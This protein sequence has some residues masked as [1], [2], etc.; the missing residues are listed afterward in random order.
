ME[1]IY[2]YITPNE[3]FI[4]SQ[5]YRNC[6]PTIQLLIKYNSNENHFYIIKTDFNTNSV[7][8]YWFEEIDE[9]LNF[10][11]YLSKLNYCIFHSDLY[12]NI[13][14]IKIPIRKN[15][16]LNLVNDNKIF[17]SVL[18]TNNEKYDIDNL[19]EKLVKNSKKNNI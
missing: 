14:I 15:I 5:G 13:T 18:K 2:T 12:Y 6:S 19:L 1:E 9:V 17:K 16:I 8:Q 10:I 3:Q 4:I 7:I 11:N